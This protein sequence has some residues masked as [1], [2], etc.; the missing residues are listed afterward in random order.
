MTYGSLIDK[1]IQ[2]IG[3]G[4]LEGYSLEGW[5]NLTPQVVV[6]ISSLNAD[7]ATWRCKPFSWV[8]PV[9][10][11]HAVAI[12]M[13]RDS[14]TLENLL[15]EPEGEERVS[16]IAQMATVEATEE[17]AQ[18]ILM[19]CAPEPVPYPSTLPGKMFFAAP[20]PEGAVAVS[21]LRFVGATDLLANLSPQ[22][23]LGASSHLLVMF[24]LLWTHVLQEEK[25]PLLHDGMKTFA[26]STFFK[27]P[28]Y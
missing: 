21:Q 6:L 24:R 14:K 4:G 25:K 26:S 11:E 18:R 28:G 27:V 22:F 1:M 5:P 3:V 9:N 23:G 13:R 20:I 7:G 2:R 16:L 10:K 19:T 12:M 8:V 15:R 17:A